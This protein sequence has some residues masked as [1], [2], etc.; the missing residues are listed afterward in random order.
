M[1][2]TFEALKSWENLDGNYCKKLAEGLE[3]WLEKLLF[4]GQWYLAIYQD[5]FLVCPKVCVKIG[6][7]KEKVERFIRDLGKDSE[8]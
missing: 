3:I 7:E 1:I 8:F 5:G 6:Y 4:D 2:E